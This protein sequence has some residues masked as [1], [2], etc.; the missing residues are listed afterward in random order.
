MSLQIR[1]SLQAL[2]DIASIA[3]YLWQEASEATTERFL[4][5]VEKAVADLAGMPGMGAPWQSPLMRLAGI[6]AWPVPGFRKW[7]I[8]YRE[9]SGELEVLRVLHGARDLFAADI[10][11]LE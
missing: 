5:A 10:T 3:D 7:L 8:F 6:R 2:A 1:K 9:V 11:D 4:D